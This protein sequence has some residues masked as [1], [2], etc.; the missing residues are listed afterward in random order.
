MLLFGFAPQTGSLKCLQTLRRIHQG[1][2]VLSLDAPYGAETLTVFP[3]LSYGFPFKLLAA[4]SCR[5]FMDEKLSTNRDF[6]KNTFILKQGLR[7]SL[8]KLVQITEGDWGFGNVQRIP[9]APPPPPFPIASRRHISG[10]GKLSAPGSVFGGERPATFSITPPQRGPS[11]RS[12]LSMPRSAKS[13]FQ[14]NRVPIK[15]DRPS[16]EQFNGQDGVS[17]VVGGFLPFLIAQVTVSFRLKLSWSLDGWPAL[18]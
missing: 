8:V 13:K 14:E 10:G 9:N 11:L 16:G 6:S 18:V 17:L 7:T 15:D 2:S 12:K 3:H 4:L 1:I 5:S